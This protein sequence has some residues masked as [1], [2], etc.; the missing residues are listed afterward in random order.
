MIL[1]RFL[2]AVIRGKHLSDGLFSLKG[3][4]N[5]DLSGIDSNKIKDISNAASKLKDVK[6]PD[7]TPLAQNLA[8][9]SKVNLKDNGINTI[10]A[11]KRLSTA[12][13]GMIN[14]IKIAMIGN[15]L[16]SLF[17]SFGCVTIRLTD[18]FPLLPD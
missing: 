1:I 11:I 12:K 9:L 3:L 7:L 5:I 16:K 14:P 2:K 17:S 6:V 18:L 4:E 8:D 13:I 10:N 15:S